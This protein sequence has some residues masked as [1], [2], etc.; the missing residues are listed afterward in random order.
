MGAVTT[1]RDAC[2]M[3]GHRWWAWLSHGSV[4]VECE[5][6]VFYDPTTSAGIRGERVTIDEIIER[7]RER[8]ASEV[9]LHRKDPPRRGPEGFLPGQKPHG[10]PPRWVR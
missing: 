3:N 2:R 8:K 5:E 6:R 1:A 7:R 9:L 10:T 4:C